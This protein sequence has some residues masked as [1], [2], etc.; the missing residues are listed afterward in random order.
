MLGAMSAGAQVC[1]WN[2][3]NR[4][5]ERISSVRLINEHDDALLAVGS[6]DGYV[7]LWAQWLTPNPTL[8][9]GRCPPSP[10]CLDSIWWFTQPLLS[11]FI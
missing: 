11:G 9:T 2:N 6:S 5:D 1:V 8:V 10:L 3:C 7:R 4:M